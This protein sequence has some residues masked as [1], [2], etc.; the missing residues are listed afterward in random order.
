MRKTTQKK[1]VGWES[2]TV[3]HPGEFLAETLEEF[4]MSQA[5]LA[6]RTGLSKKLVNEIVRGKNPISRATAS[7]LAN[8]FSLSEQY[9]N[10]LQERY[11]S[12]RVRLEKEG[13][14]KKEV[15]KYLNSFAETYKEISKIGFASGLRNVQSNSVDIVLELQR[16]FGV[17][18]LEYVG[19]KQSSFCHSKVAFRKYKGK[20]CNQNTS[21]AWLRLGE[22]KAQRTQTKKFDKKMLKDNLEDIARM[23][24]EDYQT[25]LP[26]LEKVLRDCGVVLACLPYLKRTYIQGASA[27]INRD[28]ALIMINTA[29]KS[30]DRFWFTLFHEIGHILKHSKKECFIDFEETDM[31]ENEKEADAFAEKCLIPDFKDVQE[32]LLP[33][34]YSEHTVQDSD[35]PIVAAAKQMQRSPAILAGRIAY[36]DTRDGKNGYGALSKF[37]KNTIEYSNV[38]PV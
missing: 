36:E 1:N 28:T 8:V 23:S 30:E 13:V 7:C 2:T 11:D 32:E 34:Q 22:I 9:W 3:F 17:G 20:S 18:S 15:E 38:V 14:F 29:K 33:R 5:E 19:Q 16:F 24:M 26:K 35:H 12:D 21:L 31:S 25:Y 37:F 4:G 27:W 6:S 10:N